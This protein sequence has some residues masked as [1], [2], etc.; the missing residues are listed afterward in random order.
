MTKKK[1]L[2]VCYYYPPCNAVGSLRIKSFSDYLKSDFDI[3]VMSRHWDGSEASWD[4]YIYDIKGEDKVSEHDGV[5]CLYVESKKN[6][7]YHFFSS[8]NAL[9]I[10]RWMRFS[11]FGFLALLG[12]IQVQVNGYL[13][14]R[15][16]LKELLSKEKF[17]VVLISNPPQ[18]MV[19]LVKPIRQYHKGG[20]VVDYRDLFFNRKLR[21]DYQPSPYRLVLDRLYDHYQR[22]YLKH[23]DHLVTIVPEFAGELH[24]II[25]K[26]M[27]IIY[28]GYDKKFFQH[29]EEKN[30]KK[31]TVSMIGSLY[32]E[33]DIGFM[34]NMIERFVQDKSENEVQFRFVGLNSVVEV[35]TQ[36]KQFKLQQYLSY[37]RRV[38]QQEAA[39]ETISASV[40]YFPAWAGY[41]GFISTKIFDYM[42][43]GTPILIAPGDHNIMDQV[44]SESG[45]GVIAHSV[46][47]A[48]NRLNMF[49]KEWKENGKIINKGNKNYVER[50]SREQQAI[51]LKKVLYSL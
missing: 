28:N 30:F 47:E 4:D 3:T 45:C 9:L 23:A 20:I 26:P 1:L 19:R 44:V 7:M 43:S 35:E 50:Y 27:S 17:D 18:N 5:R 37:E 33:Q 29:T 22:K 39:N 32:P 16:P 11:Y 8:L 12:H 40:L 51:E 14:F 10:L 38:S 49:Y 21:S 31:F 36:I 13:S 15:K 48:V 6:P 25:S 34:L 24:R 2:I 42:A 46:E 41:R